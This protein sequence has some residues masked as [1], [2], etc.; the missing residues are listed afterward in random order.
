MFNSNLIKA[1]SATMGTIFEP[2]KSSNKR[3]TNSDSDSSN[4]SS[5][6][7]SLDAVYLTTL[8]QESDAEGIIEEKELDTS[9]S[10][11]LLKEKTTKEKLQ[12][13]FKLQNP[14]ELKGEFRCTLLRSILLQGFMYLTEDH[15]CFHAYFPREQDIVLKDGNLAKKNFGNRYERYHF[16]L[17]NDVLTYYV[18]PM[19]MYCPEEIIDLKYAIKVEKTSKKNGFKIITP[20]RTYK[21]QAD[22]QTS[23]EEWMVQLERS[24]VRANNDGDNVKIVIPIGSIIN[25]EN[26]LSNFSNTLHIVTSEQDD[27]EDYFFVVFSESESLYEEL[28]KCWEKHKSAHPSRPRDIK[29]V[30]SESSEVSSVRSITTFIKHKRNKSR[31]EPPSP[32]IPRSVSRSPRATT[33]ETVTS[34]TSDSQWNITKYVSKRAQV[35]L[36]NPKKYISSFE[37]D[38]SEETRQ[39]FREHFALPENEKLYAVFYGYFLRMLPVYGKFYVSDNYVCFKSRVIGQNTNMILPIADIHFFKKTKA[40]MLGYYGLEILTKAQQEMFFEFGFEHVRDRFVEMIELKKTKSNEERRTMSESS[41]DSIINQAIIKDQ[42]LWQ[43]WSANTGSPKATNF[44]DIGATNK[45]DKPLHITCLTIGSRGD[46]QPYIALAKGLMKEG[47]KVRISTHGEYKDWVEGHGI[48]FGY[49]GGNPAELMRICVENG[50]FTFGFFKE[51]LTNFREWLDDLLKTSWE[52]CQNTD[53]IIESPSC[54]SG[55]HIA[56]CLGVAYF[57]AF[58]MPWTRTRAYPHAFAVPDHDLKGPYNYSSYVLIENAFWLA[59]SPQVNRW[60]KKTLKLRGTNLEKMEPS[61]VPFL[62][63]FSEYIVPKAFDWADWI[64][65]TGYWFLDNP[66]H[67]WNPPEDL[68]EFL[69]KNQKNKKPIVY[70]GFGS[71][72]VDDPQAMTKTI[73]EAVQKSGVAAILSKG[74]SDR[75]QKKP[76]QNEEENYPPSIYSL[77]SVPHDWLFPKIDAVVHHGGAGTTAAGLRAGIPTIIKPFFGDQFFWGDRIDNMGIG[78]CLKKLST[79]KLSDYLVKVTTDKKIIKKAE[80][81]GENIRKEDGV[82]NAIQAIYKDLEGAKQRIISQRNRTEQSISSNNTFEIEENDLNNTA[83]VLYS[84]NPLNQDKRLSKSLRKWIGVGGAGNIT[85][86]TNTVTSENDNTD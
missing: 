80:L 21:F 30:A 65:V 53:V 64:H 54:M 23:M 44:G 29:Q 49:V 86:N 41:S 78:F 70:I 38:I 13:I 12:E 47:H 66:D 16:T 52:A 79:D 36:K 72:V 59:I 2:S 68:I 57:R 4:G 43:Q 77:K 55:I 63:N 46:V 85:I 82:Q 75:L 51:G 31:D 56:E 8:F 25:I 18:D 37:E 61:T 19:D 15:I 62:Y 81:V 58:T 40:T 20:K 35:F 32:T 17:Q 34:E 33:L 39:H 26:N 76:N 10:E 73:V 5:G 71:I 50:M 83:N 22:S 24:I 69:N 9:E 48:E 42:L 45:F 60:R 3:S 6:N 84:L 74:W 14:E 67:G 27:H 28:T 7:S 1:L 11:K